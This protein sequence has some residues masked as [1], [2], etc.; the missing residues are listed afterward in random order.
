[1]FVGGLQKAETEKIIHQEYARARTL[2]K[3][4]IKIINFIT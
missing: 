4:A 2:D 3:V 1:M